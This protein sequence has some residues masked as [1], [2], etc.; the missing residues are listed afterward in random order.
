M[1][2]Y[3]ADWLFP[4]D[5]QPDCYFPDKNESWATFTSIATFTIYI[6]R[7]FLK[8]S[9]IGQCNFQVSSWASPHCWHGEDVA[10]VC[11]GSNGSFSAPSGW[12][13]SGPH[14]CFAHP[15]SQ[16]RLVK[17]CGCL[18]CTLF[19]KLKRCS[20]IQQQK[21]LSELSLV[22]HK[23]MVCSIWNSSRMAW[24]GK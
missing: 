21:C 24:C 16:Y 9:H 23:I 4:K 6:W 17:T 1:W 2:Y 18:W 20:Y 5:S 14:C 19:N 8:C 10:V 15:L 11:G 7:L 3:F 12:N 22:K 13:A